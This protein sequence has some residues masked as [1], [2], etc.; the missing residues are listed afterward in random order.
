MSVKVAAF[1]K[2]PVT[3]QYA[4]SVLEVKNWAK[5]FA[6][7]RIDF[8]SHKSFQFDSRCFQRPKIEGIVVVSASIDCQLKPALFF[9]P[10]PNS[11]Y[12]DPAKKEFLERILNELRKWLEGQLSKNDT[13]MV[14]REMI[15][16]ELKSAGFEMHRLRYL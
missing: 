9:Y 13:D 15:L 11:K 14:G 6:D 12:L 2:L 8:G 3:E 7:L 5:G 1:R 10:I 4:C 16:A